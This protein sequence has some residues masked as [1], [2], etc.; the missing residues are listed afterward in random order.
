MTGLMN[1]S[2]S[3]V[4]TIAVCAALWVAG[5][6]QAQSTM[7]IPQP[8][9]V[10]TSIAGELPGYWEVEAVT[11]SDPVT[12]GD[13]IDPLVRWRFE[14]KISPTEDLYDRVDRDTGATIIAPTVQDAYSTTA[15]GVASATFR[16]GKW[17]I[18][19][20][21]E[22]VPFE[23][24]GQPEGFFSGR[25]IVQGSEDEWALLKE[26]TDLMLAEERERLVLELSRQKE[27]LNAEA[28]AAIAELEAK[29]DEA[30]RSLEVVKSEAL[31]VAEA[32]LARIRE[33]QASDIAK[34]E[35][36]LA[37]QL[38]ELKLKGAANAAE[39]V[40]TLSQELALKDLNDQIASALQARLA[41]ETQVL[42]QLKAGVENRVA[43]LEA[44]FQSAEANGGL[45]LT[46]LL[47]MAGEE[48]PDW[49]IEET[50]KRFL[51]R[52]GVTLEQIIQL[53]GGV[54]DH[55]T[56]A[57]VLKVGLR[58]NGGVTLEQIAQLAASISDQALR[59]E[60][61]E[62]YHATFKD[63]LLAKTVSLWA[64]EVIEFSSQH[65]KAK[66][67][68]GEPDVERCGDSSKAWS[69][70]TDARGWLKVGFG[71]TVVPWKVSIHQNRAVGFVRSITLWNADGTSTEIE[72]DDTTNKCPGIL[73]VITRNHLQAIDAIT[74]TIDG[75]HNN[76][77][78]GID[79]ISIVGVPVGD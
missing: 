19:L 25:V 72:V 1:V 67:A 22:N 66:S 2:K 44:L 4:S 61:L 31:E 56:R 47:E 78:A 54:K 12:S 26:R 5:P 51:A 60:V 9:I 64:S 74:V 42:E 53:A 59:A 33:Q 45:H 40:E 68:L 75:Q 50:V 11:V 8:E 62:V 69:T 39:L 65:S 63:E 24:R 10:K 76:R 70:R 77:Y 57:E 15:Y 23:E 30:R 52:D 34:L 3:Y 16:A 17:S 58:G 18:E 28:E 37:S 38:E 46:A 79:A 6:L 29:R 73:E 71:Q 48:A 7:E 43:E 49:V 41:S 35:S 32:E 14:A 21:F 13:A 20:N 36:E 27:R 55:E